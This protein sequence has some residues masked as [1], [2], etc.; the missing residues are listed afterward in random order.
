MHQAVLKGIY[1]GPSPC[2]RNGLYA[3]ATHP[4]KTPSC[5]VTWTLDFYERT[6]HD[7]LQLPAVYGMPTKE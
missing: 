7:C 2:V 1:P 6:G 3:K 5:L 4:T